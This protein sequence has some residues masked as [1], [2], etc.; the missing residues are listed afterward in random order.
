MIENTLRIALD[1]LFPCPTNW[2]GPKKH[3]APDNMLE[4]NKY[5]L[6]FDES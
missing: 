3:L 1:P 5:E 4:I 6:V 2:S